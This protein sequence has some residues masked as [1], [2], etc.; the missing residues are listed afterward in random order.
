MPRWFAPKRAATA[1][2]LQVR[3]VLPSRPATSSVA[4]HDVPLSPQA[5]MN[6]TAATAMFR[7]ATASEADNR[8]DTWHNTGVAA[9]I[10]RRAHSRASRSRAGGLRSPPGGMRGGGSGVGAGGIWGSGGGGGDSDD[11]TGSDV[12][13]AGTFP[14]P[15][16]HYKRS[17]RAM[18]PWNHKFG[19]H[20]QERVHTAFGE[21][22][23]L[24]RNFGGTLAVAKKNAEAASNTSTGYR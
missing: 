16:A 3:S 14:S 18:T 9:F 10:N 6:T 2:P 17:R 5:R 4:P 22:K 20:T 19:Q 11:H 7:P 24:L 15:H 12:V 23:A 1:A 13:F 21:A 8:I